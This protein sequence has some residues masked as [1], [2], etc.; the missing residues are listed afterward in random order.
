MYCGRRNDATHDL[1]AFVCV[2]IPSAHECWLMLS[3]LAVPPC[4][5]QAYDAMMLMMMGNP[6]WR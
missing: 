3:G 2:V 4:L 1:A 5:C 6:E